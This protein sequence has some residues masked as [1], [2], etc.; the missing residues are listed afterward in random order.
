MIRD[1]PGLGIAG[2]TAA[3]FLHSRLTPLSI[4]ASILLGLLALATLAREE[5]P[6]IQVPM[7]DVRLEWP[8]T[9]VDQ[10][11]RQLTS[12]VER[13]LWEIPGLEYLY[14]TS[15]AD[16]ALLIARFKVGS[17]ADQALTRVRTRLDEAEALLPGGA[18]VATVSPRSIDDV[19]V[20]ALTLTSPDRSD[21]DQND[22]RRV[23]A[24]LAEELRKSEGVSRVTLLGGEPRRL[25]IEPDPGRLAASN[26]SYDALTHALATAGLSF[27]AGRVV[28]PDGE[29]EIRA[30]QVG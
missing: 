9:P 10:V 27:P 17:N 22:L 4:L 29:R 8:G 6:Q 2:R 25:Q 23:A 28:Q 5:E 14:S 13:Q 1:R 3:A 24:E 19:P 11:E 21:Q 18:R 26:I 12:P 7:V 15:T 16:G 20:L 30:G